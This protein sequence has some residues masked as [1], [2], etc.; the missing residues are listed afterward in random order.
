MDLQNALFTIMYP[1]SLGS[2]Q[3]THFTENEC[4]TSLPIP[5]EASDLVELCNSFFKAQF[6]AGWVAKLCSSDR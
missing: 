1:I 6:S 2:D 3:E 4:S 5:L